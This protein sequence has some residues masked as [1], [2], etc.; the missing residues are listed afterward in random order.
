M[1]KTVLFWLLI[2]GC[3]IVVVMV[4]INP[5]YV[6]TEFRKE[7]VT[8][9]KWFGAEKTKEIY[10]NSV[11]VYQSMFVD[12]GIIKG[13]YSFFLPKAH[14]ESVKRNAG[15]DRLG[16]SKIWGY[17]QD[18]LDAFWMVV[19]SGMFRFQL[20]LIC[21]LHCLPFLIPS[22]VDGLMQR[23]ICKT[24]ED[25]ASLNIYTVS[26]TVLLSVMILPP[27][28][29]VSPF[30]ISPLYVGWWALFLAVSAWL[31]SA[32]VQHRI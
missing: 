3:E 25:N 16:K 11:E 30:A 23:E 31:M 4:F 2:L 13:S 6:Q 22:L 26:K 12:T 20:L 21:F 32:N 27:I 28:L 9:N 7:V 19:K 10:T 18:R 24:S 5:S 15:I 14:D 29:L 1:N 8:V 17:V